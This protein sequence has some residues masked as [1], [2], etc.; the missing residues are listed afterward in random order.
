MVPLRYQDGTRI[1]QSVIAM[2]QLHPCLLLDKGYCESQQEAEAIVED[3][4]EDGGDICALLQDYLS[5]SEQEATELL[6][7]P[8]DD[9]N[10]DAESD[11][12]EDDT[13]VDL[14][15]AAAVTTAEWLQDGH[16]E[17]CE[18]H[19]RLTRHH[20]VPR[21]TW[22][23]IHQV[24]V[25]RTNKKRKEIDDS[26][27]DRLGSCLYQLLFPLPTQMPIT[28]WILQHVTN[29][30]AH[31]CP[32]CHKEIHRRWDAW[33]LATQRCTVEALLEDKQLYAHCKWM[34]KQ[35]VGKYAVKK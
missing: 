35:K 19:I 26:L 12:E 24:I 20:L 28:K 9:D 5:I 31:V 8:L 1:S 25:A 30:I 11:K 2:R 18:R 10:D 22:K 6:S 27:P 14:E 7:I 16:C 34:H 3:I 23:K 33:T 21:T 4:L 29:P 32:P 13:E 17:L 15:A